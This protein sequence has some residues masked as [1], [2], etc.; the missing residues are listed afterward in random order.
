MKDKIAIILKVVFFILLLPVVVSSTKAFIDGLNGLPSDLTE[1]F[2]RGILIYLIFHVFIYEPQPVYQY[3]QNIVSAIF[4]FFAP[5]VKVAPFFFPIY[6]LLSLILFYFGTLIFKS[7]AVGHWLMFFVSFTLT[8]HMVFTAKSL[9]DKDSNA[10]KPNY[11]FAMSV[12]YVVNIFIMALMLDLI[13]KEFS[14]PTFF[15]A[16]TQ[17]TGG[18]YTAIFRQ[19]FGVD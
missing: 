6:S 8:M 3:G 13:L 2:I 9:R 14:F 1:F 16:T 17:T 11:F 19:L 18:F 12:I 7:A 5:L 4:K 10:V 15:N